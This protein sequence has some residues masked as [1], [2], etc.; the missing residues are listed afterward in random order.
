MSKKVSISKI[1]RKKKKKRR[2]N[3]LQRSFF[4][5]REAI[6]QELS[7][8]PHKLLLLYFSLDHLRANQWLLSACHKVAPNQLGVQK[9][10]FL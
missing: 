1:E 6:A 3:T 8:Q 4:L 10:K 9:H 7:L 5:L 2:R